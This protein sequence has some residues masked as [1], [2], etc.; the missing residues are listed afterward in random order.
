[1]PSCVAYPGSSTAPV[2][3]RHRE[4]PTGSVRRPL[5]R[6]LVEAAFA[7]II[8]DLL[9]TDGCAWG[10]DDGPGGRDQYGSGPEEGPRQDPVRRV[11]LQQ[12]L[13]RGGGRP[14]EPAGSLQRVV[15]GGPPE[16]VLP[17]LGAAPD[18]SFHPRPGPRPQ[19][20]RDPRPHQHGL[21]QLP[22]HLLPGR[23]QEGRHRGDPE[24]RPGGLRLSD[25]L[26]HVRAAQGAGERGRELQ[27]QGSGHPLPDRLQRERGVHL[28]DHAVR[29]HDPPRPV[30]A[31]LDRGRGHPR[32]VQ[33]RLLPPQQPA[34]PG[35]QARPGEGQE[36]RGGG[37]RLLDGRGR[38]RAP[39]HRR[40]GQA[41]RR[42]HPDR[43]GPLDVPLRAE[44]ARGGRALRARQGDRLPPR[45][46]LEVAG[47]AGRLRVRHPGPRGL[48]ERLRALALL[49][50][51]PRPHPRRRP[52]R[53][54]PHRGERSR[55]SEPGSGAT[56]PSCAAASRRR[57]STS[58]SR[59]P[60]SCP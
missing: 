7:G 12:L 9:R 16:R 36:A 43:R 58:A 31:R 25:P 17:L 3:S 24:V 42:P 23:G 48:R 59:T 50:L 38:L 1:M 49:L 20:R 46:V 41:P 10:P 19:D 45:H 55:S 15:P 5:Q 18:R 28:R 54:P 56:S 34:R 33:H 40:G 26:G 47:R 35:A 30:L 32:Q 52:P 57:G 8:R 44:R 4:T 37:G 51:Q 22:R 27:G 21:V 53:R 14:P 2:G 29:G 6:V 11:R 60:R 13:L 39:R